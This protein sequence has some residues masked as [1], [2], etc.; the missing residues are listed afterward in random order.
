MIPALERFCGIV[1]RIAAFL[2]AAITLLIAASAVGRY[3]FASP[4]PDAFDIG[5]LLLGAAIMWGFAVVGY[6]GGH[7][8]ETVLTE[9]LPARARRV[10]ELFAWGVLLVFV[11]LLAWKML[12]RVESAG[13]SGEATFDLRLPVWPLM[14]VIWGGAA[15]AILTVL[16][17][18]ILLWNGQAPS[19]DREPAEGAE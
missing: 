4:I 17:R 14:A 10:I 6:R 11:A 1:E 8:E 13:A 9:M 5:R 15:A 12:A 3:V 2:L 18:I 7:I 19:H 16:A